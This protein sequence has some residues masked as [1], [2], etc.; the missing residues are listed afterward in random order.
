[1][2]VAAYEN[3]SMADEFSFVSK[4]KLI[5]D[6]K[7][8]NVLCTKVKDLTITTDTEVHVC[9]L[10]DGSLA[11][12]FRG[13][14]ILDWKDLKSLLG[15]VMTDL[16]KDLVPVQLHDASDKISYQSVGAIKAHEGFQ[17]AFR[18]VTK[19]PSPN[20]NI[21]LVAEGLGA[22]TADVKRVIC[23]GHSL[24]GALATLCAQ[25]CR[26][27]GYATAEACGDKGK[28]LPCGKQRGF[29]SQCPAL[30]RPCECILQVQACG[31]VGIFE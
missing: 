4:S 2:A 30:R 17:L 25:W 12:A 31:W 27:V 18:D 28:K 16:M 23:I 5:K 22:R 3:K 11:F 7:R 6:V 13:T 19:S 1:M 20:E 8:P 10:Q 24:G 9:L 29:D 15:D 21:R 14:E 26:Y